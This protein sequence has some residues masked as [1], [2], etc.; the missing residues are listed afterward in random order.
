[1][2]ELIKDFSKALDMG[3][4]VYN[5][6]TIEKKDADGKVIYSDEDAI[7][8]LCSKV[9][10]KEG[11]VNSIE[12]LRS[13]NKL[14]IETAN[15]EAQAKFEQIVNAVSDFR[16]VG[17]Y[18]TLVYYT[19]PLRTQTTVQLSASATGVDYI[20][21]PSTQK[22]VPAFAKKRQFGSQYQISEMVSNPVNAFRS[23]VD[24]VVEAKLKFIF[25]EIMKLAKNGLTAGKIPSTQYSTVANLTFSAFRGIENNLI[26]AG[27]N[28]RPVLIAD[29]NF[30]SNLALKQGT[31]GLGNGGLT[32]S[33]LP[34]L[35]DDM[36]NSLLRDL[37]FDMVSR[38]FAIATDNPFI[39]ETNSK[40][41][42]DPSEALLIAGGE[43]SPFKI[44]EFGAMRLTQE[45]PQIE[46][47]TVRM[48]I[49]Y[50]ID[51]TLLLGNRLAYIQ[52]TSIQ[53]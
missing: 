49:D 32:L 39:D 44:T 33:T 2:S 29:N 12:D 25:K 6:K 5:S 7:K 43:G 20:R 52:D 46:D 41:D 26:R 16:N 38:S 18:D 9:F 37:T 47:E 17:T 53:L 34:W 4:R 50:I 22:K 11:E 51:V 14:I 36:K 1:M 27:K 45:L 31:E 48:K 35:T 13:F 30:I 19:V 40:V 23:A 10:S 28:T 24:S 21:I 8:A 42:L 3:K 15:F